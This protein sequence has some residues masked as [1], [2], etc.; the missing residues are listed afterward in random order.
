M[1]KYHSDHHS[2]LEVVTPDAPQ[3]A[4]NHFLSDP[5]QAPQVVPSSEKL[6]LYAKDYQHN[7]PEHPSKDAEA[8]VVKVSNDGKV[9]GLRKATFW[10]VV[11]IAIIILGGAIGGGV[12]AAVAKKKKPESRFVNY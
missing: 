10:L 4:Q 11:T 1:S 12:G 5:S 8:H 3:V 6:Q 9:L 7:D 2:G